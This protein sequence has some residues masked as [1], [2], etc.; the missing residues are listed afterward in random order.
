APG[1]RRLP[2]SARA[3]LGAWLGASACAGAWPD[4][5]DAPVDAASARAH[6]RILREFLE[7]HLG[8]GK[9]LR[10]FLAWEARLAAAHAR[11]A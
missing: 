11:S 1:G 8:D 5:A 4:D 3:T 7:E 2:A 10:A 6:A 9:P